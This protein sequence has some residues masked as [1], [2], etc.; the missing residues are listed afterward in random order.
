LSSQDPNVFFIIPCYRLRDVGETVERY[1]E[2]F[3]RNGHAVQMI[4][5]DDSSPVK[6]VPHSTFDRSASDFR[7]PAAM[8]DVAFRRR[9]RVNRKVVHRLPMLK[10][11]FVHQR[12]LTPRPRVHGLR[13][14]AQRSNEPWA[15]DVG[16]M[17]R[18]VMMGGAILLRLSTVM[19][20]K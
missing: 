15:M 1:D 19:T 7:L 18:A 10:G 20:S 5:F 9:I 13:S 2:H 14:R 6:R 16:L 11:W 8:G 4:V 12:P 17:W 3:W